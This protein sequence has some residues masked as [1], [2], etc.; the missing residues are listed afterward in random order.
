MNGK[1]QVFNSTSEFKIGSQSV[2]G[3]AT[4]IEL[5]E[6]EQM[7]LVGTSNGNF[8]IFDCGRAD[9]V[10]VCEIPFGH[11]AHITGVS[12]HPSYPKCWASCSIDRT[13]LMWDKRQTPPAS[14]VLRNY[15]YELTSVKWTSQAENK[16]L[17]M[18]GDAAGN[19]LTLDTRCPNKI[20][21]KTRVAK[22]EIT[23]LC[24][25]GSKRFGVVAQTNVAS[26]Y[27]A[28]GDNEIKKIDEHHAPGIIY[29]MC[30]D[31]LE[32]GT[33]Y[34]VGERKYAKKFSIAS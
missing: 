31:P 17:V 20:L 13:C 4:Q 5:L 18:V 22:R 7:I 2:D 8:S 30:S 11:A 6:K 29:S 32:R 34:V 19:V 10:A 26:I 23:K 12:A 25:N 16:D 14:G 21:S 1:V 24:F 15:E 9:L 33:F 27:E 28:D 3:Y